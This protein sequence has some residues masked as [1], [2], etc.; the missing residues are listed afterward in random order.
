MRGRAESVLTAGNSYGLKN[1]AADRYVRY[2]EREYG[3][4]LVW[5]TSSSREVFFAKDGSVGEPLRYGE[6]VALAVVDGGYVR[7]QKRE[8]GINLAWSDD[9]VYEWE[10]TGGDDG[11]TIPY[12]DNRF[13]LFN[14]VEADHVVY[15]ERPYGINL[16]WADDCSA[17]DGDTGTASVSMNYRIPLGGGGSEPSF[18]SVTF[19]G[20][21]TDT[22]GTGGSASF[23]KTDQWEAPAGSDAGLATV[24]LAGLRPGAW[25]LEARSPVW[26]ASCTVELDAGGNANVNFEQFKSGCGRGSTFPTA[27]PSKPIPRPR[28]RVPPIDEHPRPAE[29]TTLG[30]SG[31][32]ARVGHA[33]VLPASRA[34]GRESEPGNG[35]QR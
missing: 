24:G 4:N 20:Q 35:T 33:R 34:A 15:C 3:I 17:F 2:G 29:A 1:T 6:R 25:R 32:D 26:A 7:Y 28:K 18:G 13:G 23:T 5:T 21:R 10:L 14:R 8:Y 12:E 19:T 22:D 30:A 9:P 31:L 16:R 11:D 27:A